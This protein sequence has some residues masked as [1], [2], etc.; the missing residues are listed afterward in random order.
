MAAVAAVFLVH[1]A[2][3]QDPEPD[4][5][6]PRAAT[7]P[8]SQM[9]HLGRY[10]VNPLSLLYGYRG[11]TGEWVVVCPGRAKLELTDEEAQRLLEMRPPRIGRYFINTLSIAYFHPL[12]G[13][14]W[15]VGFGDGTSLELTEDEGR[16]LVRIHRLS[17]AM[18]APPEEATTPRRRS[19]K[20]GRAP[21]PAG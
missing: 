1:V 3:S 10:Y 4:R 17:S 13:G 8:D 11:Q 9:V 5:A 6:P 18:P 15:V 14:N 2:R 20:G 12:P 7:I 19:P 16:E 21:A